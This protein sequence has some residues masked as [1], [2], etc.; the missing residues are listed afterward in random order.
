MHYTI[1]ESCPVSTAGP[2]YYVKFREDDPNQVVFK[3]I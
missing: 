3:K 2:G 1:S